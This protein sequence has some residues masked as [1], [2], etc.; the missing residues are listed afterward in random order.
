MRILVTGS[1]GT[2]GTRLCERLLQ[3]GVEVVGAD[4]RANAWNKKIDA[5]THR[6]DLR[7]EK[8]LDGL[9]GDFDLIVHL[10]AN[11]RVYDLV[12]KP[13]DAF[14][15][16]AMTFNVLEFARNRGV[17]RVMFASSREVYGNFG[18]A[19]KSEGE[20]SLSRCES[21]YAASK[22]A[23]EAL[24]TSYDKCYG[25]KSV[26]FRF[27]N[28][29]GM[30]D[31]SDRLVP[32][33]IRKLGRNEDVQIFG[34]DKSLDFTYIDDT[35]DGIL[36]TIKRFDAAAGKTINIATG[37]GTRLVEVAEKMKEL[38]KS[39]SKL[40]IAASRTGEVTKYVAD[41]SLAQETLGYAPKVSLEEGLKRSID[42][43]TGRSE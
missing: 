24:V 21:P 38:M 6:A 9:K 15:N 18:E 22:M 17:G 23:G 16:I 29:Y 14:D 11:A 30:Y 32:I 1:S 20:V 19:R 7:D 34:E 35:V 28:V 42:W 5:L 25:I 39:S 2:I 33:L 26:I 3:D 27:S 31:E 40:I 13:K 43:Y 8:S 12:K 37:R 10:A 36:A 41:L 4:I